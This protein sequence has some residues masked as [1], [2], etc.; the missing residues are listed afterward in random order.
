MN[1]TKIDGTALTAGRPAVVQDGSQIRVGHLK[2]T[3][4]LQS[5]AGEPRESE[6]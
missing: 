3:V 1:G 5:Q 2:L 6:Q 4:W